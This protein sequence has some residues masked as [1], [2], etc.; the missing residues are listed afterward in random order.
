MDIKRKKNIISVI[1]FVLG[2]AAGIVLHRHGLGVAFGLILA[3]AL[4]EIY[5][6][7]IY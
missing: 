3:L 2:F 5:D 7:R 4:R 1:G 6:K